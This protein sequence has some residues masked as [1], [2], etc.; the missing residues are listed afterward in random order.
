MKVFRIGMVAT[1]MAGVMAAPA[2]AQDAESKVSFGVTGGT[3]GIG[4]EIGYRVNSSFGVR[5]NAG[6]LSV[7]HDFDVD[8]IDYHGKLKL[9]S[10]GLMAD[11]YPFGG[12]FRL[13]AGARINDNKVRLRATPSKPVSVGGTTY[14][15]AEIGTLSGNVS[16]KDFTPAL[17]LGWG[18]KLAEGLVVGAEAGALFQGR[19]RV[20]QLTATGL[21]KDNPQFQEDLRREIREI[22]EDI[23]Q[24]KVY[25]VVQLTVSY[26]F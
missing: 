22:E 9:N 25:P 19:P 13:S 14:T 15:P 3:L 23:D 5:A 2:L 4:P 11:L 7:G 20:K 6:W 21:L 16:V 12:G 10:Y 18:G 26:R 1:L 17:T 24:Y 8:D